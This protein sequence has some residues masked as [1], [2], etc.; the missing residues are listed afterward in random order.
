MTMTDTVADKITRIRNGNLVSKTDVLVPYSKHKEEILKVLKD[1][2]FIKNYEVVSD[3]KKDLKIELLYY[4]ADRKGITEIERVSKPGGRVYVSKNK[5]PMIKNGKG[6]AVLSTS[7]G[8]LDDKK[9]R[10]MEVGGE[11]LFYVW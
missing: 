3:E 9:A 1:S 11:F 8:V 6:I 2:K 10:E 7:K 4:S 5:I